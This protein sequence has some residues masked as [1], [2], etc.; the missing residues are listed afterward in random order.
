MRPRGCPGPRSCAP[1]R[2]SSTC[3]RENHSAGHQVGL[4][5]PE[6]PHTELRGAAREGSRAGKRSGPSSAGRS[7]PLRNTALGKAVQRG[8]RSLQPEAR[9]S[10]LATESGKSAEKRP[11][12]A[13]RPPRASE[14]RRAREASP[15]D[16]HVGGLL[17]AGLPAARYFLSGCWLL[18]APPRLGPAPPPRP[19]RPPA[20][21][22]AATMKKFFQEIK[23]DIKFKSAGPGQKLTESVG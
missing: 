17:K 2:A 15:A 20:A 6:R 19:P 11:R 21:G 16:C 18:P 1:S 7:R 22:P 5:G 10:P 12:G 3:A 9:S 8:R 4:H 14:A 23:A 13:E